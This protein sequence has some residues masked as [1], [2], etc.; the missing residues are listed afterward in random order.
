MNSDKQYRFYS[1]VNSQ[2]IEWLWYPYIPYGKVTLLQGDP[3][4]GKSTLMLNIT[5]IVTKGGK[6][7]DGT[8]LE[9]PQT[10]IYQCAED[11]AEDT[12]KPR[13]EQAGA[14]CDK[15]AFIVEQNKNVTLNDSRI[16]E[17]IIATNA[18]MLV[19]DPLQAFIS[20]DS[21]MHSAAKMRSV[22]RKLAATA[23]K[24]NCAV[25]LVGHM[26]KSC[27]SKNLYRGLGSIDIAAQARSVL[28]IERDVI[29]PQIRY[30]FTVKSNLAPEGNTIAFVLNS[31]SGF[32]WLGTCKLKQKY[33]DVEASETE[34]K[35]DQAVR[36]LQLILCSEDLPSREILNT[37]EE[38][39]IGER[40]VR[41]AKNEL[42]IKAYRK[43][44]V[45]YW[46]LG[47]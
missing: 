35:V 34:S 3:G 31:S 36:Y 29:S 17:T 30:M 46:H 8:M 12:I 25:V 44:K 26:T 2:N 5:A 33:I 45:W 39:G 40:T 1:S 14:N 24:Y 47:R 43:N 18:R 42:N 4:E 20:A 41:S 37:M 11:N 32:K 9:K 10:V 23:Q 19:F 22:M 21:D 16:E 28:M 13:L 7:P 6:M 38:L 27:G 15:V